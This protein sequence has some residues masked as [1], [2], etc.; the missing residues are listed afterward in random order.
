MRVCVCVHCLH[1]EQYNA[2]EYDDACQSRYLTLRSAFIFENKPDFLAFRWVTSCPA[3][4][5]R[6]AARPG[7]LW[8]HPTHGDFLPGL[9]ALRT[10]HYIISH[11]FVRSPTV[12]PGSCSERW[13]FDVFCSCRF[14]TFNGANGGLH[15]LLLATPGEY[16]F[17]DSVGH[18]VYTNIVIKCHVLEV[19]SIYLANLTTYET[20]LRRHRRPRRT[21][22]PWRLFWTRPFNEGAERKW[23]PF[24]VRYEPGLTFEMW[25][26]N[27][28]IAP[29]G[30]C[31]TNVD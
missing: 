10:T 14:L 8:I 23:P 4:A 19:T 7:A 25:E 27:Y 1:T 29:Y 2:H 28:I 31:L 5:V 15:S 16:S 13:V 17:A 12:L 26:N 24:R 3:W 11:V 22:P 9:P 6:R 20:P 18:A 30:F 21:A